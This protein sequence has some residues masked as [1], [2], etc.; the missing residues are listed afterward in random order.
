LDE[1]S[2]DL[3]SLSLKEKNDNSL[4]DD[5]ETQNITLAKTNKKPGE[6]ENPA[7]SCLQLKRFF[8]K[9]LSGYYYIKP[10]CSSKTLRVF[11]DFS[12]YKDVVEFYI[13]RD[14]SKTPNPDL[15]YL[16]IKTVDDI[17][18]Q[19][20]RKGLYPIQLENKDMIERIYQILILDGY[21]LG[22]SNFIPLGM[23]YSCDNTKCAGI[24]NSL[25]NHN[26]MPI[27]QFF[28][29]GVKASKYPGNFVGFGL[30]AKSRL[31]RFD[32][33][34]VKISGLVCSSNKF[35]LKKEI[36][37]TKTIDCEMNISQNSEIFNNGDTIVKCPKYCNISKAEVYGKELY[38]GNSSICKAAI[39]HGIISE[40]GGK[41]KVIVQSKA[42]EYMGSYANGITTKY[43]E[44]DGSS[45]FIIV[46][47]VPNCPIDAFP[48]KKRSN[49][50]YKDKITNNISK[51]TTSFLEMFD[52][53]LI[54]ESGEKLLR[55]LL[56]DNFNNSEIEKSNTN[57]N[58]MINNDLNY[59]NDDNHNMNYR[60]E[61]NVQRFLQK[62]TDQ[63]NS[64]NTEA[65][66]EE[67]AVSNLL[68]L[69]NLESL[70]NNLNNS[71]ESKNSDVNLKGKPVANNG[72]GNPIPLS[73]KNR[74][75]SIEGLSKK[76]LILKYF[77]FF[78]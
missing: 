70:S 42:N 53:N 9:I 55:G 57:I 73:Q 11:C 44:D 78:S 22:K 7:E 56:S 10:E 47:Y 13:F 43:K 69:N 75:V 34:K 37:I 40:N 17:K 33:S 60:N 61:F 28:N 5:D 31:V 76:N 16:N 72:Q 46:K 12:L 38:H 59:V 18:Y 66:N 68:G 77:N 1:F 54:N 8:T 52:S 4:K 41:I 3:N 14:D 50:S 48:D 51:T 21:D 19:C 62:E 35:E 71:T 63:L 45:G 20:S 15:S 24:Y 64:L 67:Y 2:N 36:D 58:S 25:N 49:N 39:H 32:I 30:K 6:K 74:S 29:G 23:D 27:N 65:S 26:T